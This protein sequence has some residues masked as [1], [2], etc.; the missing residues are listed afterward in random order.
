MCHGF[1]KLM[2]IRAGSSEG[3]QI[4]ASEGAYALKASQVMS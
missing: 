4:A 3:L 2:S 1:E